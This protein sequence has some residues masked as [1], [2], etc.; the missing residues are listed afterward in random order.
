MSELNEN[1]TRS[2]SDKP[3]VLYH[4]SINKN[5]KILEPRAV[6]IRDENE[7]PVVFATPDKDFATMFI[8]RTD[9]SWTK[10]GSINGT[11]Y[12]VISDRERFKKMDKGGAIYQLNPDTFNQDRKIGMRAEWASKNPVVPTNKELFDSGY[13]AMLENGVQVFFVGK[14]TF[15]DITQSNDH[16][17]QIITNLESENKILGKNYKKLLLKITP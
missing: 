11:Y 1:I 5:V 3:T 14:E 17:R 8:V 7:G 13:Q 6:K 12:I 10:K 15:E 2:E 16:G 4:A 9:D